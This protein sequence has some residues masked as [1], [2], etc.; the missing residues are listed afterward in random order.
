MT[1]R[2]YL[3]GPMTGYP[4]HNYP[5]FRAACADL[6]GQGH[7]V[8]SPHETIPQAEEGE[9][10]VGTDVLRRAFAEYCRF[11]CL[12]ADTIVLL[13]GWE[14]SRGAK[15]EQSLARNCGLDVLLYH[16]PVDMIDILPKEPLCKPMPAHYVAGKALGDG[17]YEAV[18]VYGDLAPGADFSRGFNHPSGGKD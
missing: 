13:P 10:R 9:D 11:I 16:D 7:Y 4:E 18:P 8:Y 15:A 14:K 5:A 1:R 3:A 2:I 12:E 6:R 17:S